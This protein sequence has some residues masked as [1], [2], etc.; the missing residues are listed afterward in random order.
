MNDM[1]PELDI[2]IP[3]YNEGANIIPVLE[4]LRRSLQ[5]SFRVLICY[6]R[7]DDDTLT[8]L[9]NHP[10]NDIDVRTVKNRGQGALGAV[11]TGFE[12]STADAVLVFPADDDYNTSRLDSMVASYRAGCEIVAASR[13]MPGGSMVGCPLLKSILVRSVAWV[14][15]RL[16]GL[17]TH[18]S[19]NGFRL[20]SRRV[21]QQLPIETQAGFAYSLELLV[22]C[23]RLGWK[24]GEV[25][26]DWYERKKG[27]SRF[28]IFKWA[29]HYLVWVGYALATRFL[30]RGPAS[31]PQRV[32]VAV[33]PSSET[34]VNGLRK[35]AG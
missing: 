7:D 31:V 8:A 2:V 19:T 22:K 32:G 12:E 24:V 20:F 18:D 27:Q 16:I 4:G 23:H 1:H 10:L 26:V 11:V 34:A 5:T 25:P 33:P 9:R 30:G 17:P 3:V 28:R 14:L 35:L 13:F 29:P 21:L 15:H 6:D